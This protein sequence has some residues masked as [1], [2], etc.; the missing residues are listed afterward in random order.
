M[1]SKK[2][3]GIVLGGLVIVVSLMLLSAPLF[4][5]FPDKKITIVCPFG[6]GGGSDT[7]LRAFQ[8]PL[9]RALGVP[10]VIVNV[11]G[12]GGL[13]GMIY[14]SQQPADGYTIFEF[15]TSHL[16]ASVLKRSK[17]DLFKDFEIIA[18]VQHDI[19]VLWV[20]SKGK[21]QSFK[22]LLDWAKKHPYRLTIAGTS[23]M[24]YDDLRDHLFAKDFGIKI[25]FVPFEK[26]S[27]AKAAVLGGFVMAHMEEPLAI[28][29]I[30]ESGKG[31]ALIVM[32]NK[33]LPLWKDTPAVNEFG[34]HD[35]LG[36]FRAF[37]IK[38]GTPQ[39]KVKI[40]TKAI[41]K[42]AHDPEYIEFTKKTMTNLRPGYLPGAQFLNELKEQKKMFEGVAKDL[43]YLKK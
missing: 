43:G 8:K 10:I 14:A 29:S 5:K 36:V 41:E 19:S 20:S 9:S 31:K 18:R 12:G 40:I 3:W 11:S 34:V 37:S 30:I 16:I 27:Q 6:V 15:T 25:T 13:K 42:A 17:V 24:G 21:F 32:Y 7:F 35:Y 28:K 38:K 23:P 39:D 4:A 22:Q 26:G 33:R 2:I 1:K